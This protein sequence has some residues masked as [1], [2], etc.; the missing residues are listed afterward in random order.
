MQEKLFRTSAFGGYKKEDV[1]MYVARLEEELVRLQARLTDGKSSADASAAPAAEKAP[2]EGEDIIVFSDTQEA[3]EE[4]SE[5]E[6]EPPAGEIPAKEPPAGEVPAEEPSAEKT[7][8]AEKETAAS[9]DWENELASARLELRE[10]KMQLKASNKLYAQSKKRL[11]LV[12]SEKKQLEDEA[13]QLREEKKK[14]EDNYDAVKEVLMNARID[15]EIIRT[16]AKNEAKLLLEETH[17]RIA[18][19]KEKSILEL[20]H[21]LNANRT[22]LETSKYYLEEQVNGIACMEKQLDAIRDELK[23]FLVM[24][25]G[26]QYDFEETD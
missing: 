25:T 17:R 4:I 8:D 1:R 9:A 12:L 15:A 10:T 13:F 24:D 5:Q 3:P 23:K 7:S 11:K 22:G 16:K 18:Q 21:A 2:A 14:Y 26:E 20:V 6:M 19:E